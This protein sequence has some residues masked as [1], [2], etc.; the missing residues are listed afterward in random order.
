MR[1]LWFSNKMLSRNDR[2]SSGTWLDAM[3][4]AL[5]A[6]REVEL[7]NI[8]FG[9]VREIACQD[10]D[11]VRQWIV[12]GN[13]PLHDGLPSDRVIASIVKTVES[14]SPDLVHV[15]GTEYFWGLLSARKHI[16]YPVLL[17]IQGLKF[18]IAPVFSG[19][20]TFREQL[21][22][23]GLR[24]LMKGSTIFQMRRKYERWGILEREIISGHRFISTQLKWALSQVKTIN[25]NGML[26]HC[27][28]LLRKP[29]YV[30]APH[31]PARNNKIFCSMAYSA[32]FKGLHVAIRAVS[33]LK[34][35]FPD[36]ELRIAGIHQKTGLRSDGYVSWVARK[37]ERLG[38][39]SNVVWLGVLT[40]SQIIEE[41]QRCSC[42]LIPSF[43]ENASLAFTEAMIIGTPI[44]ASFVGSLPDLARDEE[45]ALF[46]SPGDVPVCAFQIERIFSDRNLAA[47]L[48]KRARECALRQHDPERILT[49]QLDIYRQVCS[50]L[51][52]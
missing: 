18:A 19:G 23:I 39:V 40:A 14:F 20:L 6:S 7:G 36:I 32:P 44:V 43:I 49:M 37:I 47:R 38:I 50:N 33:I 24:E 21:S 1:V 16:P 2:G 8:T 29:F 12:P 48:S 28:C 34:P 25:R 27:D 41:M 22:C 30:A 35:R 15:W 5:I 3:S 31:A 45:S 13:M 52:V 11:S 4:Q 26:F 46:F 42:V 51:A 17:E 10:F 9:P